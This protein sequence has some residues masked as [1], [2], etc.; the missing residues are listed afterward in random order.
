MSGVDATKNVQQSGLCPEI[1]QDEFRGDSSGGQAS[2]FSP[3]PEFIP[4]ELYR[5]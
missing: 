1:R 5:D 2:L 3:S 4:V